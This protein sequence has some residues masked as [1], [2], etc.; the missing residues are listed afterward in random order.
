MGNRG[1]PRTG[2]KYIQHR[3][4]HKNLFS[5]LVFLM[6]NRSTIFISLT[7]IMKMRG[8]I[9]FKLTK[10]Q[11]CFRNCTDIDTLVGTYRSGAHPGGGSESSSV[12]YPESQIFPEICNIKLQKRARISY[13]KDIFPW[14]KLLSRP[15][16]VILRQSRGPNFKIL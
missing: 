7:T 4:T 3:G 1:R 10:R 14:H 12:V 15:G 5:R 8:Y 13:L 2:V 11:P 16:N 9:R 6:L